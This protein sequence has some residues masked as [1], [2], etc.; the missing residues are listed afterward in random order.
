MTP[1]LG[2][3]ECA[4]VVALGLVKITSNPAASLMDEGTSPKMARLRER[5]T[6]EAGF[7][8]PTRRDAHPDR[9]HG[10]DR[11]AGLRWNLEVRFDAVPTS[12]RRPEIPPAW[13]PDFSFPVEN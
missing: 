6:N 13:A 9:A 10:Q 11:G 8:G 7:G 1:R 2:C 12:P 5:G 4:R 3:Q